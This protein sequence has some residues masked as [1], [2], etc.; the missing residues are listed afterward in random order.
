MNRS[1]TY[2]TRFESEPRNG[3]KIQTNRA[4]NLGQKL[5]PTT[6]MRTDPDFG[7]AVHDVS[8]FLTI[9][10]AFVRGA[11]FDTQKM[12]I[13]VIFDFLIFGISWVR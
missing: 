6:K 7:M 1:N 12:H 2:R 11:L 8:N 4:I 9:G 5:G 13:R 10:V 3:P